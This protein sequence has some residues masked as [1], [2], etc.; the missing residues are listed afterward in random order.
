MATPFGCTIPKQYQKGR[1]IFGI[2]GKRRF[3]AGLKK[4]LYKWYCFG[5]ISGTGGIT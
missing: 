4:G 5:I 2:A 3:Q 1:A